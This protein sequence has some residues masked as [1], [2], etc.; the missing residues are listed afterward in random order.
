M[1]KMQTNCK[2][3]AYFFVAFTCVILASANNYQ[4]KIEYFDV[5]VDHFSYVSNKTFQIR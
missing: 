3:C 4:Y 1:L 2:N 5:P